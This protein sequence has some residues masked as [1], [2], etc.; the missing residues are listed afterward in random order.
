VVTLYINTVTTRKV[1][2]MYCVIQEIENKKYNEYGAYK[3]LEV[4]STTCTTTCNGVTETTTTYSYKYTGG[5]FKRPVRKAYKISIHKSYRKG[6]KVKKK[7][8]VLCTMSYYA[9]LDSCPYDYIYG[10]RVKDLIEE[11]KITEDEFWNMVYKKFN[12]LCESIE[13]EFQ[14]TE[15]YKTNQKH[16]EIITV[17]AAK[18]AK[19]E[20]K[21]GQNTYDYCYDVFGVLRNEE[22]LNDIK[23]QYEARQEYNRSYYE[24]SKSNYSN[25]NFS[26]YFK[27]NDSNYTEDEK[28]YLKVI[29]KAA[30]MKLHPDIKKDDGEG[31][32]F[33][34]KLKEQW[35]I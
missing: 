17:Y 2:K 16:E 18:K 35:G 27:S 11:M 34:N 23:A 10:G 24:N 5:R 4:D 26:G 15:E 8:W 22:M 29:Y 7:Q 32:K 25:Y 3:K 9:I 12:P 30:A 28:K 19:F 6:G 13:K 21:Y 14:Q 33:L 1:K 20:E 31:M